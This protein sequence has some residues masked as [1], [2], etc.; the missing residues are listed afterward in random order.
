MNDSE[1]S[2]QDYNIDF[3]RIKELI[4]LFEQKKNSGEIRKYKEED[5]KKENYSILTSR[6]EE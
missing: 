5:T 2:K 3:E 1:I 4:S 6:F